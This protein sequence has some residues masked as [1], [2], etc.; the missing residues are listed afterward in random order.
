MAKTVDFANLGPVSADEAVR[1]RWKGEDVRNLDGL[2]D[3]PTPS[4]EV[5][6]LI[7]SGGS[8][9]VGF[10]GTKAAAVRVRDEIAVAVSGWA[11]LAD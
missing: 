11:N 7:P 8:A 9:L 3:R 1:I 4:L 2:P 5:S 10:F 6:I